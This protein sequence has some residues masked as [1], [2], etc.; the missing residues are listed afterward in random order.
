MSDTLHATLLLQLLLLAMS[1]LLTAANIE[2]AA[3]SNEDLLAEES[4][5]VGSLLLRQ[6]RDNWLPHF[7]CGKQHKW[8]GHHDYYHHHWPAQP[9]P[10][11]GFNFGFPMWPNFGFAFDK[12]AA[13]P[14]KTPLAPFNVDSD[15]PPSTAAPETTTAT[16]ATTTAAPATTTAAATT[17]TVASSTADPS[18]DIDIRFGRD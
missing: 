15:K 7:G 10:Y 14:F 4:A 16:P 6:R 18:L 3:Y 9:F 17:T 11:A 5:P 8:H 12:D 13:P 2:H 1:L